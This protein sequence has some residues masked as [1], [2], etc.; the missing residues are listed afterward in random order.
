M[1][2]WL[3]CATYNSSCKF[4]IT[5][6]SYSFQF[7]SLEVKQYNS[8]CPSPSPVGKKLDK[9]R[10]RG[11][12]FWSSQLSWP[13][14]LNNINSIGIALEICISSF[15]VP[16]PHVVQEN[17]CGLPRVATTDWGQDISSNLRMHR[18]RRMRIRKT[19]DA[20]IVFTS[21]A[22]SCRSRKVKCAPIHCGIERKQFQWRETAATE[23]QA[24]SRI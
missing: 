16:F 12:T 23:Q 10:R 5:G 8:G 14:V 2:K 3:D 4:T 7:L 1:F 19:D 11:I 18:R 21:C 13:H 20:S 22:T 15:C 9:A 6:V 24:P 17:P